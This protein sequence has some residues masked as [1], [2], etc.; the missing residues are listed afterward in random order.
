MAPIRIR[1][2]I[3]HGAFSEGK[4]CF[5]SKYHF[6]LLVLEASSIF[7]KITLFYNKYW[8]IL[9]TVAILSYFIGFGLRFDPAKIHTHSRVI[10]AATSVLWHMK[11]FDFLSVHPRIGPYI[12][13]G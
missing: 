7:E 5:Y 13:V 1:A 3:C 4:A 8:N 2:C 11:L 12:T 9:T 10:L 6:K